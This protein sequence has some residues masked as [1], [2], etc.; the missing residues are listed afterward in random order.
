MNNE[1]VLMMQTLN[2]QDCQKVSG[3]IYFDFGFGSCPSALDPTYAV[4]MLIFS[5][6]SGAY[7]HSRLTG[8][9]LPKPIFD[10]KP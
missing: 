5:F 6:L 4:G 7:A 2:T 1:E 3:G 10:E 9:K 8:E